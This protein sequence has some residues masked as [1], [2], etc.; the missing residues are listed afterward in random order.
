MEAS[1]TTA[2]SPLDRSLA[3]IANYG[4]NLARALY[5]KGANIDTIHLETVLNLA[6]QP[7]LVSMRDLRAIV[8]GAIL[9]T[10]EMFSALQIPTETLRISKQAE[11]ARK[12]LELNSTRWPAPSRLLW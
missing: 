6:G 8:D 11:R 4:H 10:R 9:E 2:A 5:R 7:V 3:S 1:T 12:A